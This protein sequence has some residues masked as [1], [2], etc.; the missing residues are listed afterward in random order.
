MELHHSKHHQTYITNLN[1]ALKSQ[2]EAVHTSDI[3]TQVSLQQGIKF[4]AGGHINHS[5]FW[6]NLA[7][8]SSPEARSSAAPQLIKQIQAVWGDEAK[9]RD[10]FK[11]ALL[12]IQ[13]SGW[14]WLGY[15]K[16]ANKL[17]IVTTPNQ[18]PLLSVF[19]PLCPLIE[20]SNHKMLGHVPLIGIDIWEHAFYLQYKN[21]KADVW[22]SLLSTPSTRD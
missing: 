11:A 22:I 16:A 20:Y 12:G 5:L 17:E 14:G 2:A 1:A 13:G 18:D 8:A 19:F 10:A 15:N 4:N 21:V 6:Q 7:P 3:T 9:F